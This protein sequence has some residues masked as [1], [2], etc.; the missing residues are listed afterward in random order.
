MPSPM[1]Q[2]AKPL[3]SLNG[4]VSL[5]TGVAPG[6]LMHRL[7]V[8]VTTAG[9]VGVTT[10]DGTTVSL[11]TLPIGVYQL[12]IEFTSATFPAGAAVGFYAIEG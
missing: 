6:P 5:T 8:N 11:G 3:R 4:S 1:I 7:F 9:A 12:D 10:V 2:D